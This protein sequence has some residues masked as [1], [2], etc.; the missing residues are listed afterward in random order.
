[1]IGSGT[2]TAGN[3][4]L[5]GPI[6][7]T[8]PKATLSRSLQTR[9][10]YPEEL[11]SQ[12]SDGTQD[13]LGRL[14]MEKG[15][16]YFRG[17]QLKQYNV[18]KKKQAQHEE[19]QDQENMS[20][21]PAKHIANPLA[22]PAGK[23]EYVASLGSDTRSRSRPKVKSSGTYSN[24]EIEL[25]LGIQYSKSS[26]IQWHLI[27]PTFAENAGAGVRVVREPRS[28]SGGRH[29]PA[30]RSSSE[31]DMGKLSRSTSKVREEDGAAFSMAVA[32]GIQQDK[33]NKERMETERKRLRKRE[34]PQHSSFLIH[35]VYPDEQS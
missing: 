24:S 13:I 31:R 21:N 14:Y 30:S 18:E 33:D 22:A 2:K 12:S 10:A 32:V 20:R 19:Q 16:R 5:P 6:T 34:R 25:E 7:Q 27:D 11:D 26:H 17:V 9:M 1:M 15:K 35:Q 23:P 28:R 8:V 4:S 3:L 29:R